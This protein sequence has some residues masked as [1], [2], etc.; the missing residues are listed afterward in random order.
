MVVVRDDSLYASWG[1]YSVKFDEKKKVFFIQ[2]PGVP[3]AIKNFRIENL[4]LGKKVLGGLDIFK[5]FKSERLV[6]EESDCS[7]ID[8]KFTKGPESLPKLNVKFKI[9]DVGIKLTVG[10]NKDLSF[11]LAGDLSWGN[12]DFADVYPMSSKSGNILRS[13]VGPASTAKDDLLFDRLTDKALSFSGMEKVRIN[14]DWEKA[15]YVFGAVSGTTSAKRTFNITVLDDVLA[16]QYHIDYKPLNKNTTFKKPPVGWMTW[17]SVKFTACEEKVLKN[18]EWMSKNLKDYGADCVWVDWE[19]CHKN[20]SGSRD[21]GCDCFNPDKE[22]Y[23]NGL[24]FVSDKIREFG[25]TPCLWMGLVCDSSKN[26]FMQKRPETVYLDYP[27]WPGRY[28]FD[29]THP[30]YLNEFLPMALSKLSE[31]GYDAV[32]CDVIPTAMILAET[33]RHKL[34]NKTLTTK[35]IYRNVVKK[36]RSILGDDV[37]MLSCAACSDMD[38]LWGADMFD[39]ARVGAD[40]FGWKEFLKQGV[41]R[42]MRYYPLHNNLFYPDS[43]NVVMREEFNTVNQAASRIY[44][45]SMLGIPMTF[46]DEFDALDDARIGFI[47]QCMPVLEMH[48]MDI[49]FIKDREDVLKMHLS[50]CKKWESYSVINLFN[51]TDKKTG[52]EVDFANDLSLDGKEYIVYNYTDDVVESIGKKGFKCSLDACESK[53]FRITEK[54][55]RPQIISTSRHISQGA[56]EIEDMVW[57]ENSCELSLD[58]NLIADAPYRVTLYVPDG[59]NAPAELKKVQN[60]VYEY[61]VIPQKTGLENI[62]IKF[63]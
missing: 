35:E 11:D 37:Y 25:L 36:I 15:C 28:Y 39:S 53:I 44:F 34:Y 4:R 12:N 10:G 22:K 45:V 46:G 62:K 14:Y 50:V 63:N 26:E 38:V 2:C 5:K 21:D 48:P 57:N 6:T 58:A 1:G 59:F 55:A 60:N 31:W 61:A 9:S 51:T 56:A 18:A 27:M 8:M 40:I 13:A 49:P 32:K 41:G 20:M 33:Y 43:D 3:K 52:A 47:K 54:L 30:K 42:T 17:Y 16:N 23:P 7:Y 19:W 29:L 24:K